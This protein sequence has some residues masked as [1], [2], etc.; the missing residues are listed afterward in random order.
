MKIDAFKS[1]VVVLYKI[2]V[3]ILCNIA[4]APRKGRVDRNQLPELRLPELHWSRPARGAWIEILRDGEHTQFV[5]VAPR[6]G[7][8]DRN[9]HRLSEEAQ[10]R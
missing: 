5:R 1:I 7:R 6:K 8:V 10:Q 3:A 2:F 9:L 4:V